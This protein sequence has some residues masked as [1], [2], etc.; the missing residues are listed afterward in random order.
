MQDC[1]VCE[2]KLTKPFNTSDNLLYWDC[3]SCEVIFLDSKHHIDPA[4]ER[5][6]YL[7]HKNIIQDT[8]Y[9]DFLSKLTNPLKEKLSSGSC[10]LDFGCGH[11]PALADILTKD[12]FEIELY[13]PFFYPNKEIFSKIYDFITCT[14]T[15]EHFFSPKKEFDILNSLLKPKGWLGVMTCFL[16]EREAFDKWYYRRDPTHVVFYAE[17]TFEAIAKQRGWK[18]EIVTKDIVLFYKQ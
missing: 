2:S 4:S 1:I 16:T 13:D 10:G 5:E 18:C 14:E 17:K 3:N 9:R 12:G 15:A 11:G 6:R 8:A 7:E